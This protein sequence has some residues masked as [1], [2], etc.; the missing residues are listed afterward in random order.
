MNVRN[1]SHRYKL[2]PLLTPSVMHSINGST[3]NRAFNVLVLLQSALNV[4]QEWLEETLMGNTATCGTALVYNSRR[5][6]VGKCSKI[7]R[8]LQPDVDVCVSEIHVMKTRSS[9]KHSSATLMCVS[10]YDLS[11]RREEVLDKALHKL[12]HPVF[13]IHVTKTYGQM[14]YSSTHSTARLRS[15][16]G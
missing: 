11:W 2:T 4:S 9:S 6:R 13:K 5:R 14:K 10:V 15:L 1:I 8:I 7:P 3:Q 16:C 12:S